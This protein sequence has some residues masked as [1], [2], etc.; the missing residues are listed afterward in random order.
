MKYIIIS[1]MLAAALFIGYNYF[2]LNT[3][4]ASTNGV[5]ETNTASETSSSGDVVVPMSDS[6]SV[7]VSHNYFGI[8]TWPVYKDGVNLRSFNNGI[9]IAITAL[10][11]GGLVVEKKRHKNRRVQTNERVEN[12]QEVYG[13]VPEDLRMFDFIDD[14]MK[15]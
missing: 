9:F 11:V 4:F 7:S 2:I 10:M 8:F 3:S 6:V 1:L 13:Y 14:G 12:E 15:Q 5:N